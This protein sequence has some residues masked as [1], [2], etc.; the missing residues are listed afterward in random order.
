MQTGHPC[1]TWP[2]IDIDLYK[3]INCQG[4]IELADQV[5]LF[6]M[7]E[8]FR[9]VPD[10]LT[11]WILGLVAATNNARM[12]LRLW[13]QASENLDQPLNAFEAVHLFV[14]SLAYAY[15]AGKLLND[16]PKKLDDAIRDLL[17]QVKGIKRE[18]AFAQQFWR[19]HQEQLRAVRELVF[20]YPRRYSRNSD[21]AAVLKDGFWD[22]LYQNNE[23]S[24]RIVDADD[25]SRYVFVDDLYQTWVQDVLEVR[26]TNRRTMSPY[27]RLVES[28]DTVCSSLFEYWLEARKVDVEEVAASEVFG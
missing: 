3:G 27:H 5:R 19:I 11:E 4:V 17:G 10:P 18:R 12:F 9:Q 21:T 20:H 14:V 23:M 28:L 24:A 1:A 22:V 7:G 15:E 6:R 13:V 2:V 25:Y 8:L 16:P 26:F